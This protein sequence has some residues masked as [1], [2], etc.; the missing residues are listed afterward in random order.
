MLFNTLSFAIFLPIVAVTYY[1][2]PQKLRNWQLLAACLVFYMWTNPMSVVW[3]A[4][5]TTVT[6]G[7]GMLMG[8]DKTKKPRKMWLVFSL[9]I[10]F[11][12]LLVFK[13]FNLFTDGA[14][15]ILDLLHIS[16]GSGNVFSLAAPLGI[17]FYTF[18]AVGYT[19]DVY[20][21]TKGPE[22]N[23]LKYSV[24][25]SFFPVILSGPI[26]RSTELIP[27]LEE[28]HKFDYDL[29]TSGLKLCAFGLFKKI[30]VADTIAVYVD[31]VFGNINAFDG[32]GL[33]VASLLFT[34]QIYCD[35]SGY[36][37]VA[38][39]VARIMG[40]RLGKNF[41]HPYFSTSIK[42]FWKRW[43]ISLSSWFG[44]YL[45]ISM[46]G[47]RCSK[48]RKYFNIMVTFLVSGLWHGASL[49]F[50]IWGALHGI[51]RVLGEITL[52]LRNKI[53]TVTH[54]EK[55]KH[56]KKILSVI[57]TFCL[58]SFAWIF[59]KA[60]SI[61]DAFNYIG[62]LFTFNEGFGTKSY[63]FNELKNVFGERRELYLTAIVFPTFLIVSVFDYFKPLGA[64]IKRRSA[65][66]RFIIY[67]FAVLFIAIF[68]R[69]NMQDFIYVQ[70]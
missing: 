10:N 23:F 25:V 21:G 48:P 58:V 16:H 8:A 32:F 69:P 24:F 30:V 36:S 70:F 5:T 12:I 15:Y 9:I 60:N 31:K 4:I 67:L 62:R 66:V 13:Y 52:P 26:Q 44:S 42:D 43:H 47:N 29:V 63:F 55:A 49:T 34:F 27:Q 11:G 39:G 61:G 7:A 64:F 38:I 33:I 68:A 3:L 19:I 54:Y 57:F 46:G 6:W 2:T 37:D 18:Q 59:F 56:L 53:Y 22:R 1:L 40:F 65:I 45:Y 41:D 50:I 35:F 14:Y 17:S 28:Q 20:R 51:Y